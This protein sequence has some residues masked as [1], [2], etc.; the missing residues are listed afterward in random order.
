MAYLEGGRSWP[1]DWIWIDPRPSGEGALP[2]GSLLLLYTDGLIERRG[3]SLDAGLDR[4]A[5]VVGDH[6]NLPLRRLKQA[7][8][9]DLAGAGAQDDVALVAVRGIGASR[10]PLLRRVQRRPQ[11]AGTGTA[12]AASLA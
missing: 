3:E 4:L 2:P 10:D 7:I 8:F 9:N 12:T 5:Q 1:L 11:P 6:W